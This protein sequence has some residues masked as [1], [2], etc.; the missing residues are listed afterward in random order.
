MNLQ[1]IGETTLELYSHIRNAYAAKYGPNGDLAEIMPLFERAHHHM[2]TLLI[3]ES[4]QP[5]TGGGG[6]LHQAAQ[7]QGQRQNS[8]K[9]KSD[10]VCNSCGRELTVGEK[11][12]CDD[13]DSEYICYQ[14][15]H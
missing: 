3:N 12:Y 14:C 9:P 15:S 7:R 8:P 4:K 5:K 6:Q 10:A 11:K 2:L 13:N 1:A